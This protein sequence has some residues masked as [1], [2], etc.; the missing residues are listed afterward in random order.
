MSAAGAALGLTISGQACRAALRDSQTA[1]GNS[2]ASLWLGPDEQLLLAADAEGAEIAR[3]LGEA[4]AGMPHS[5]VDVSHRQL[6]LELSGPQAATR[7][8]RRLSP[9]PSHHDIS[10][11]DVHAHDTR[12]GRYRSVAHGRGHIPPRGL[13][14]IRGLRVTLP[15]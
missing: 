2:R 4:L 14:V 6:A 10:N 8:E 3:L 7:L 9:R 1:P 11:R 15:R 12:E 5:L 13:A